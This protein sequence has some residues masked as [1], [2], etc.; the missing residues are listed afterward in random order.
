MIMNGKAMA[1]GAP[2]TRR[3]WGGGAAVLA[4]GLLAASACTDDGSNSASASA[5]QSSTTTESASRAGPLDETGGGD[6]ILAVA[7]AGGGS[8]E[9]AENGD[10]ELTLTDVGDQAV[11]FTDRP[12]RQAG[13]FS[14]S[15]MNEAFFTDGQNPPNA[16][17]E[18]YEA[19]DGD[20]VV[21]VEITSPDYDEGAGTLKLDARL[22]DASEVAGTELSHHGERA[23]TDSPSEFGR[24]ALFVDDATDCSTSVGTAI[25]IA[26]MDCTE[27]RAVVE[28][29]GPGGEAGSLPGPTFFAKCIDKGE[30]LFEP[31]I[32]DTWNCSAQNHQALYLSFNTGE[33]TFTIQ[34]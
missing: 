26:G 2:V 13:S 27:V 32:G 30:A 5:S 19:S 15:A 4:T 33:K 23:G 10:Y 24:A 16:A 8:F 28:T 34:Y 29:T 25:D 18:I 11:W 7:Q 9:E 1:H 12:A 6:P 22:L 21:V 17:L 3:R 31:Q 20:N 14:I